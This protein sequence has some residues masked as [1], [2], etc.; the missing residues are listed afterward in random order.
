MI[1]NHLPMQGMQVSSPDW[2][3]GISHAVGQLNLRATTP[4]PVYHD[5]KPAHS[6]EDPVQPKINDK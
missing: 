2:G 4:E 3:T 5:L 6:K 1:K